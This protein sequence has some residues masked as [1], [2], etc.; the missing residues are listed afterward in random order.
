MA[1]SF[2][3]GPDRVA[4]FRGDF[5]VCFFPFFLFYFSNHLYTLSKKKNETEPFQGNFGKSPESFLF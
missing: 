3:G 5:Q 4:I 2:G 1:F